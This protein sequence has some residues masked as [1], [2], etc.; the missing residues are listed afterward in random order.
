MVPCRGRTGRCVRTRCTGH[1]AAASQWTSGSVSSLLDSS[2]QNRRRRPAIS[3]ISTARAHACPVW[4]QA[5][6]IN[7][8]CS[9]DSGPPASIVSQADAAVSY[10]NARAERS[11]ASACATCAWTVARLR[12][13]VAENAGILPPASRWKISMAERCDPARNRRNRQAEHA[14][15][16]RAVER[17]IVVRLVLQER[18]RSLGGYEGVRDRDIVAAGAAQAARSPRINDP[19]HWAFGTKKVRIRRCRFPFAARRRRR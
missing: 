6:R 14:Y 8:S 3:T 17:T 5:S 18:K 11:S 4:T 13:S 12:N 19:T 7:E 10:K 2:R 9:S 15:D 16:R 1:R